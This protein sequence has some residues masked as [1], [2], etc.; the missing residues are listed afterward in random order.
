M[1]GLV[2]LEEGPRVVSRLVNVD[3]V[4]LI[5]GLKLKVRFDGIDGDTVLATFEPE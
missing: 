3:D 1:V 4:E 2:Q 5:P